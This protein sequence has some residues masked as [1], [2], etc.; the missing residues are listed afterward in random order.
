[1]TY[2]L[3]DAHTLTQTDS[4]LSSLGERDR[5]VCRVAD[6]THLDLIGW[7]LE[8]VLQGVRHF[9]PC[10]ACKGTGQ[11]LDL[12]AVGGPKVAPCIFCQGTGLQGPK[13]LPR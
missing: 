9:P 10:W 1:M 11:D 6:M 4:E 12:F 3:Q 5:A 8:Q 2:G 13:E 7:A